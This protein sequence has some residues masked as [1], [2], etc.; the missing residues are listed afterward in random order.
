MK[1]KARLGFILLILFQVLILAGWTTF[2]E[3]SIATGKEVVLQT[4]P[5]DPFDPFRGE[6]V[7]LSY[8]ISR[9]QGVP[10]T[11]TLGFGDKVYVQLEQRGEVWEAV[12]ASRTKPDD[13]VVY[14]TGEVE[15]RVGNVAVITY[16]IESYFV[17]QGK[18][19]EIER[20]GDIKVRVAINGS[21]QGFILGL[22]VDGESFRLN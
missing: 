11:E 18:G 17:P 12:R 13:G 9:L 21:G 5:I 6:Y 20:A 22:I 2:N 14:I 16:G 4:A 15:N 3:V 10:G 7:R 19:P 1:K 8:D